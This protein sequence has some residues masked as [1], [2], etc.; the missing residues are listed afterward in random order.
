MVASSSESGLRALRSLLGN[1][2][3]LHPIHA[4]DGHWPLLT[5]QTEVLMARQRRLSLVERFILRAFRELNQ[6]SAQEIVENLGLD[7]LIVRETIDQLELARCLTK[8]TQ[9]I[10]EKEEI[11]EVR[12]EL[13][14]VL[15]RLKGTENSTELLR[16]LRRE[17]DVLKARE[18][19]LEDSLANNSTKERTLEFEFAELTNEGKE[20]LSTGVLKEPSDSRIIRF[21]RC[22]ISQKLIKVDSNNL[23]RYTAEPIHPFEEIDPVLVEGQLGKIWS[24]HITY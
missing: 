18:A 20:A 22:P 7:S 3:H 21:A 9:S 2:E 6:V 12:R 24:E 23:P 4:I 19:E 15:E 1:E 17:R 8:S 11:T 14:N 5:F 10:P 16:Q 13:L